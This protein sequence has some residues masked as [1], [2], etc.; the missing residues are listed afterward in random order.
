[1]PEPT[2][3][4]QKTT[5]FRLVGERKNEEVKK[6]LAERPDLK[7]AKDPF[8]LTLLH[9]AAASGNLEL[10]QH[11]TELGLKINEKDHYGRQPLHL[12]AS[13][14]HLKSAQHLVGNRPANVTEEDHVNAKDVDD[15][16]PLLVAASAK[17]ADVVRYLLAVKG[18][19][20]LKDKA[21]SNA[22]HFWATV[23]AEIDKNILREVAAGMLKVAP[24]L[25]HE[26]DGKGKKPA[27]IAEMH[28][29]GELAAYLREREKETP[30]P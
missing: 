21:G 25:V 14:G 13:G 3:Q 28:G 20:R 17:K 27:E 6:Q 23:T 10:Q 29:E 8:G 9:H 2:P 12:A 19:P 18:D 5:L 22:L 7:T 15:R 26:K 4:E 11:L 30:A 16:T 24:E 1:M